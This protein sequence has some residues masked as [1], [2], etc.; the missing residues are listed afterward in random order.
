MAARSRMK[1]QTKKAVLSVNQTMGGRK[2]GPSQ[3]PKNKRHDHGGGE[4]HA[5]VLPHHDEAELHGRVLGVEAGGEFMLRLRQVERQAMGFRQPG[6]EE[7]DKAEHLGKDEPHPLLLGF[8]DFAQ[9]EGAAQQHDAHDRQ[10]HEHFVGDHLRPG[11]QAAEQ[12]VLVVAG[13]PAEQHPIDGHR[14]HGQEEQ[15]ADVQVDHRQPRAEGHHHEAHQHARGDGG[16][17]QGEDH[18]VGERR[19]PVVLGE[20][21]DDV[22]DD[23]QQAEGA[24]PIGPQPVLP[25]AQQP[26]LPPDQQPGSGKRPAEHRHDHDEAVFNA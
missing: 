17:G 19:H 23:L 20:Q 2:S 5:D 11:A 16:W 6:D 12:G 3:P 4:N 25:E 8:H 13:Q 9:A 7:D 21:L 14:G 15:H 22:G 1:L 18:P 24:E 26:P 10:P